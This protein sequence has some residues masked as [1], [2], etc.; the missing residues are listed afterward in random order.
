MVEAA[1]KTESHGVGN[2]RL[3]LSIR[4]VEGSETH[5]E[6]CSQELVDLSTMVHPSTARDF[7]ELFHVPSHPGENLGDVIM[8]ISD[9]SIE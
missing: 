8:C 7:K 6:K 2:E 9:E 5:P 3:K 4:Q 1:S